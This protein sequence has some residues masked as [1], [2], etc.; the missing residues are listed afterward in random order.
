MRDS[1]QVGD[2][3]FCG[4]LTPKEKPTLFNEQGTSAFF[5]FSGPYK[6]LSCTHFHCTVGGYNPKFKSRL[7][8]TTRTLYMSQLISFTPE[9]YKIFKKFPEEF[10]IRNAR[11]EELYAKHRTLY[12]WR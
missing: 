11:E 12:G 2:I 6:I 3:V 4:Y 9:L 7:S 1:F 10:R 5:V 8:S